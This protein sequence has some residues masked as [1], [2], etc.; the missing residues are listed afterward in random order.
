[1]ASADRVFCD[2]LTATGT[3]SAFAS[4]AT[5]ETIVFRE[6]EAPLVGRAAIGS[7][8][9]SHVDRHVCQPVKDQAA[10][11]GDI[12]YAYG[13]SSTEGPSPKSG[14]YL[15]VWKQRAGE[16]KLAAEVLIGK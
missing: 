7:Y 4:V 15:R 3:A 12:G 6:G 14:Y 9:A 5:D 2:Q 10:G 13:K 1:L 16:W 11:S 8:F